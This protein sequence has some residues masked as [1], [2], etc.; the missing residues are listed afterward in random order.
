MNH[1]QKHPC[2]KSEINHTI[3]TMSSPLK[4][5]T[6]LRRYPS[7]SIKWNQM[8][9]NGGAEQQKRGTWVQNQEA[10]EPPS[11]RSS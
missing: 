2:C 3:P 9:L 7:D 8:K 5:Q 6:P 11:H 4:N 1:N 10:V